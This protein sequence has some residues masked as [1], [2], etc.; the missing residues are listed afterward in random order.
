MWGYQHGHVKHE[1]MGQ[2]LVCTLLLHPCRQPSLQQT[3]MSAMNLH[4][5][6]G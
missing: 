3:D 4:S 6:H 5:A 2:L 1:E